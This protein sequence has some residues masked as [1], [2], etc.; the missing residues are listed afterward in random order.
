M[1]SILTPCDKA[2]EG[3]NRPLSYKGVL[4]G[5]DAYGYQILPRDPYVILPDAYNIPR[6]EYG[7]WTNEPPEYNNGE[8]PMRLTS[9]YERW[10]REDRKVIVDLRELMESVKGELFGPK[11]ISFGFND[12]QVL[13]LTDSPRLPSTSTKNS[14][15][16]GAV[17]LI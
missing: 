8:Y 7:K 5:L 13:Q 9:T 14:L 6:D 10:D 15:S 1:R 12:L 11:F 17:G 4:T 2:Q 16:T 3:Q